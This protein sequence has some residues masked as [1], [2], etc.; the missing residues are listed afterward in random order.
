MKKSLEALQPH[1]D[2]GLQLSIESITQ[3][4]ADFEPLSRG[5]HWDEGA[6]DFVDE[7]WEFSASMPPSSQ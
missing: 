4:L 7:Y 2:E 3:R 1:V 5:Q 6:M